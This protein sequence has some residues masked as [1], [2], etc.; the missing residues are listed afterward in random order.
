MERGRLP[1]REL[2]GRGPPDSRIY[3]YRVSAQFA[4]YQVRAE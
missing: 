2:N 3:L 4:V 1:S